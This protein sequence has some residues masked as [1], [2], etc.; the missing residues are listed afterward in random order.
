MNLNYAI[1]RSEPI[2]TMSDLRQIGSH[3]NRE[4]QAYNSNPDIKLELSKD[5]IELV[6]INTTYTKGFKEITKEDSKLLQFFDKDNRF[7][8]ITFAGTYLAGIAV[9]NEQ[10]K[11]GNLDG[12]M[13]HS[14]YSKQQEKLI[15]EYTNLRVEFEKTEQEIENDIDI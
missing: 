10:R 1:F 13:E 14:P 9:R 8:N 15:E 3:N 4:K 2:M 6:P 11:A 5:N 7:S 12:K